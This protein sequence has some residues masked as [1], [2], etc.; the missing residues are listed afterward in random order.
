[1]ALT[2]E[3]ENG[4][5][6]LLGKGEGS[7]DERMNGAIGS[8][9]TRFEAALPD[10]LA[11]SLKPIEE[12]L[13]A[14]AHGGKSDDK[15]GKGAKKED[16]GSDV[17]ARIT[18][19]IEAERAETRKRL[20]LIEDERAAEKR[21]AALEAERSALTEKLVALGVPADRVRAAVA[22]LHT[23]EKRIGRDGDG[24]MIFK[25]RKGSGAAAYDDEVSI[26]DG[27]KQWLDTSDGKIFLPAK[28][29]RGTGS[30][31]AAASGNKPNAGGGGG[32]KPPSAEERRGLAMSTLANLLDFDAGE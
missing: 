22:L 32:N 30:A 16:G 1:M 2:D 31:P 8:R 24:R 19:A 26:E 9:F 10:K 17:E 12:R 3:E 20:Q 29:T 25:L 13:A 27:I 14:L 11:A 15:G 5:R 21:H 18:A 28:G 4:L 6:K 23:E 7:L